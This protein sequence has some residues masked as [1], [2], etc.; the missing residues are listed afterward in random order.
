VLEYGDS[1]NIIYIANDNNLKCVVGLVKC[2]ACF[3]QAN[4]EARSNEA[5]IQG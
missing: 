2:F 1:F 5:Y 3:G 4:G